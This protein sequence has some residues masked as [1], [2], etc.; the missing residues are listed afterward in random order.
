[1]KNFTIEQTTIY[2]SETF[3]QVFLALGN[4][5]TTKV[6]GSVGSGGN[7]TVEQS[8]IYLPNNDKKGGDRVRDVASANNLMNS[9]F[10]NIRELAGSNGKLFSSP[11]VCTNNSVYHYKED[12]ALPAYDA[13]GA[14]VDPGF[15]AQPALD[16][17]A[18]NGG[19]NFTPTGNALTDR[20]GDSRWL[21]AVE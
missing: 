14:N 1:M 12:Y 9:I 21:P 19:I 4:Q 10:V 17:H 8:T 16:L 13:D 3:K 20:R 15:T 5:N 18:E 6:F 2:D 7:W 11:A